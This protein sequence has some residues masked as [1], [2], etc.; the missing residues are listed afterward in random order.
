MI[1]DSNYSNVF[2]SIHE[3]GSTDK[4]PALLLDLKERLVRMGISVD[5]ETSLQ[6][7][8][9]QQSDGY[10][11]SERIEKLAYLRNRALRR[12][13]QSEISYDNVV[14]VNDVFFCATDLLT[15]VV[16]SLSNDAD[17]T[18]S[19]DMYKKY[20]RKKEE[21]DVYGFYDMW[22]ARDITGQELANYD[23]I[24]YIESD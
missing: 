22:V 19:V 18:C 15:L 12:L 16:S 7:D 23:Q 3:S 6:P 4:T 10:L 17:V 5:I 13:T 9:H 20:K 2:V 1:G 14:Y 8:P 21:I 11:Q 24:I